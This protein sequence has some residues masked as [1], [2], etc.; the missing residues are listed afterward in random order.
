M[1]KAEAEAA[2]SLLRAVRA[3]IRRYKAECARRGTVV[4]ITAARRRRPVRRGTFLNGRSQ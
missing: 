4:P 3:T 2:K 1:T